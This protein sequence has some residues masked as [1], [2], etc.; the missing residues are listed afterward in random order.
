MVY[1]SPDVLWHICLQTSCCIFVSRGPV[2]DLSPDVLWYI[3]LQTFCG[4]FVSGRPVV[5][6]SADPTCLAPFRPVSFPLDLPLPTCFAEIGPADPILLLVLGKR[7]KS[8]HF[9]GR[10]YPS[11]KDGRRNEQTVCT[12]RRTLTPPSVRMCAVLAGRRQA[13]QSPCTDSK[14]K[15]PQ[16]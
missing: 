2:V 13:A 9:R 14:N 11:L 16:T 7:N 1:L 10:D 3:C 6:L 8:A 4:I 12:F 15:M 5:Y